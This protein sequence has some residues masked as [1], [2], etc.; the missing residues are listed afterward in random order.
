M[1]RATAILSVIAVVLTVADL[2]AQTKPSFA[3]QWKIAADPGGARSGGP[4]VDLTI[5]QGATALTVEYR[6]GGKLT[7][8]LDGSA[9]KNVLT[10]RGG[11]AIEQVSRAVWAGNK[12]V[13]TTTTAGGEEKR[14]FSKE[15][16]DLVVET[17]LPA[18][19]LTKVIYKP[20][21]RG[22]GG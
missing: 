3:G 17:S 15:A 20:Y 1:R 16:G 9:S 6:S 2:T 7:Y 13:V 19:K 8:K 21:E 4:G 12:I 11:A 18:S 10:G 22:F 14:T 5:T